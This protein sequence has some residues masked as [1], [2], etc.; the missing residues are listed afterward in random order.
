[1]SDKE[2]VTESNK[3]IVLD[4]LNSLEVVETEGGDYS[5]ILVDNSPENRA[6]LNAVGVTDEQI[7]QYGDEETFCILSLAF[8]MG[9][10]NEVTEN[11]KLVWNDG[12]TD[13]E[14]A[15]RLIQLDG[16]GTIDD[17][18]TRMFWAT[19][20]NNAVQYAQLYL[21]ALDEIERLN[22]IIRTLGIT[23]QN[24]MPEGGFFDE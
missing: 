24:A 10:A 19:E 6:K 4:V 3:Q 1:M 12:S 8:H 13:K 2:Q 14:R 22:S 5:A 18:L 15:Q 16:I 9:F 11:W 21:D 7:N 20:S 23:L 17:D